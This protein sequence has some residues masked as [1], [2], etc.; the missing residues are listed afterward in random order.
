MH[1]CIECS[2][3]KTCRLTPD[4][5]WV[6]VLSISNDK[7]P[8]SNGTCHPQQKITTSV[9]PDRLE[10]EELKK[11]KKKTTSTPSLILAFCRTFVHGWY[12]YV[13]VSTVMVYI[14]CSLVGPPL[15]G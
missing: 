6:P 4:H 5:D 9:D 7:A 12:C 13:S 10:E 15:L 2:N 8:D 14:V 11:M 3:Y 1:I